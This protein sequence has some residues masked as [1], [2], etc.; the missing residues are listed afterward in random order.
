MMGE[1]RGEEECEGLYEEFGT[2]PRRYGDV[3]F[4]SLS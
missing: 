2:T 3:L 1:K 4:L